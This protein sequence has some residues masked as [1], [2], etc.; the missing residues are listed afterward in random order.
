MMV[1]TRKA[2]GAPTPLPKP[3]R[4]RHVEQHGGDRRGAGHRQ[5]QHA[6]QADGLAVK[7]V[8]FSTGR[9]IH[10]AFRPVLTGR[11]TQVLPLDVANAGGSFPPTAGVIADPSP[12]PWASLAG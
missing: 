7:L 6:R 2:A 8:E 4:D 3:T 12:D 5:E 9:D 1:A 11:H 10:L